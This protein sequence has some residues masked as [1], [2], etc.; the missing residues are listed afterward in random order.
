M[1]SLV[2]VKPDGLFNSRNSLRH[3]YKAAVQGIFQFKDAVDALG[4]GVVMAVTCLAHTGKNFVF[5][6]FIPVGVTGVQ[7]A[8]VA[9][10]YQSL[11]REAGLGDTHFQGAQR[12]LDSQ[13]GGDIE[14]RDEAGEGV[15]DQRQ[16]AKA[17]FGLEV[18]NIN[19]MITNDKFCLKRYGQLQLSWSRIGLYERRRSHQPKTGYPS[20]KSSHTG[21]TCETKLAY[22]PSNQSENGRSATLGSSLQTTAPME[23]TIAS[24][25]QSGAAQPCPKT[26]SG[27]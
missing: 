7:D 20:R 1:R 27:A 25:K 22:S 4:Q 6:Q 18:G 2:I 11:K 10:V 12:A 21:G 14:A 16:I 15:R 5:R 19:G 3:R 23:P 26:N 8:V 17:F 24:S 9:V 13:G